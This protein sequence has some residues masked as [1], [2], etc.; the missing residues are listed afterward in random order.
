MVYLASSGKQQI[1]ERAAKVAGDFSFLYTD[2]LFSP[3]SLRGWYMLFYIF[4]FCGPGLSRPAA[5]AAGR[6]K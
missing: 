5:A 1:E 3:P 2:R 6:E 4:I